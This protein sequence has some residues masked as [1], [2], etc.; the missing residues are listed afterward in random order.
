MS[1]SSSHD[2]FQIL[3]ADR[4]LRALNRPSWYVNEHI[5]GLTMDGRMKEEGYC[6]NQL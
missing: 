6:D 2:I 4:G 1:S 3:I 5:Q